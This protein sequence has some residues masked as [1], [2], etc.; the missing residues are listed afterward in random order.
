MRI[1]HRY[2]FVF[3]SNP[4]T[5]SRSLRKILDEHSEIHSIAINERSAENPFY[6]HMPAREVRDAFEGLGW[7]LDEYTLFTVVRSPFTR[8]PSLFRWYV[9]QTNTVC[10][11]SE[12]VERV[13]DTNETMFHSATVFGSDGDGNRLV[14]RYL[15]YEHIHD[16]VLSLLP[17]LGI[18]A[19][20]SLPK[21][22]FDRARPENVLWT[23]ELIH[24]VAEKYAD[25]IEQFHYEIPDLYLG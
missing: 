10:S 24:C 13:L 4:R 15:G 8:V 1:S 12:F 3:L 22:G 16:E 18:P 9:E 7:V 5:A 19:P 17:T 21:V 11:F 2:K 6:H 23:T 14:D 20:E 25:D